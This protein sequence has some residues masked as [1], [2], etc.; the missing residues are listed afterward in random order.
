MQK[1]IESNKIVNN[2]K[3]Y[4]TPM[5]IATKIITNFGTKQYKTLRWDCKSPFLLI[6]HSFLDLNSLKQYKV[7]GRGRG[8]F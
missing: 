1:Q 3:Q 2:Y 6:K 8:T 7:F 5:I 4:Q